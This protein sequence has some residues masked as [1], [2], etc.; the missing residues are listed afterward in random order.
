MIEWQ[1]GGNLWMHW[2]LYRIFRRFKL[3]V[4]VALRECFSLLFFTLK[5]K[6]KAIKKMSID[7][8]KKR[9]KINFCL[10]RY[11]RLRILEAEH[12]R[13][14]QMDSRCE[15][16]VWRVNIRLALPKI[17]Q[18]T[19][20]QRSDKPLKGLL[21]D[22]H[23]IR[24]KKQPKNIYVNIHAPKWIEIRVATKH[25]IATTHIVAIL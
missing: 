12:T 21:N 25:R 11:K 9:K 23:Q 10:I 1:K 5:T 20:L 18:N 24:E 6:L 19:R 4:H 22:K 16:F 7:L 2:H 13:N 8:V 17:P 15:R 3:M 14:I